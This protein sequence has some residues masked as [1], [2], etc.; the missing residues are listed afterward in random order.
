MKDL[1]K[2]LKVS[3]K[4]ISTFVIIAILLVLI[5]LIN[6]VTISKF[7]NNAN[8]LYSDNLVS[9]IAIND[10]YKDLLEIYSNEGKLVYITDKSEIQNLLNIDE[11]ND[12]DIDGNI[13]VYKNALTKEEDEKLIAEFETIIN[14]YRNVRKEYIDLITSEKRNDLMKKFAEVTKHKDIVISKLDQIVDLNNKWSN[15]TI[16]D[17]ESLFRTAIRINIEV[18][19]FSVILLAICGTL[20]VKSI[21]KPL[22]KILEFAN[23]L[24]NYDISTPITVENAN[25]F[26][27]TGM[28]L[29]KGQENIA[30][31]IKDIMSGAED[32]SAASEEL[33]ATIEE[34]TSNFESISVATKEINCGVEETSATAEEISASVQEVDSNIV[35]LSNKSIEASNSSIEMRERADNVKTESSNAIEKTNSIYSN[36]ERE[37]LKSIEEGNIVEE[38][39][40]MTDT[41]ANISAQTNL[42]ALNAAIEAARAGEQGKGF[43]VV[44]EEVRKLAEQSANEVA[45]VKQTIEKVQ[46]AFKNLSKNSNQLLKF[47]NDKV[48]P[49]FKAFLEIGE[50]YENDGNLISGISDE[51]ASMTEQLSATIEQVNV[52]VQNMAQMAQKSSE[53]SN[54][55]QESVNESSHAMEQI[56]DTAQNQA[57]FAQQLNSMVLKFKI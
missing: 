49:Q 2:K 37:I 28:A 11:K 30:V 47:M 13:K 20:I 54:A 32:M 9:I 26:G 40:I 45:N 18:I 57:G 8:K 36:M 46:Y 4:L 52:A 43:A 41:I 19:I 12:S 17:N 16:E 25:E 33:S 7:N 6:V 23:R 22:R 5:N 50:K 42:L 51:V 53:N 15:E 56:A 14:T 34:M 10:V 48:E 39:K 1:F 21:T 38:I 3:T 27:Q 29:N 44:A 55:I 24:A 35:V 31:L